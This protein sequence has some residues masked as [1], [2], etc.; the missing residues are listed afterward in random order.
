MEPVYLLGIYATPVRRYVDRTFKDLVREACVNTLADA[1]LERPPDLAWPARQLFMDYWGQ[2]ACRAIYPRRPTG[3]FFQIACPGE[4]ERC[5]TGSAASGRLQEDP[6]RRGGRHC[7]WRGEAL[8]RR[9]SA[10][11]PRA[12]RKSGGQ[13]DPDHWL[14]IWQDWASRSASSSARGGSLLGDGHYRRRLHHMK[15]YGTTVEQIALA[16]PSAT[17]TGEEPA[18]PV[19]LRDD[20]RGGADRVVPRR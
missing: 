16:A 3:A 2:S 9:E 13:F 11:C 12:H 10:S 7:R 5:A 4:R 18:R 6:R 19:S 8:R 20:G 15:R 17:T 1:R 14:A